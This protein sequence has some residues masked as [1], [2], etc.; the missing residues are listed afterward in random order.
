MLTLGPRIEENTV[1]SPEYLEQPCSTQWNR[2]ERELPTSHKVV[3]ASV[4]SSLQS[5]CPSPSLLFF[6]FRSLSLEPETQQGI[7]LVSHYLP[8]PLPVPTLAM[9]FNLSLSSDSLCD[10]KQIPLTSIA[11]SLNGIKMAL[12]IQRTTGEIYGNAFSNF[13]KGGFLDRMEFIV[14]RLFPK[15][16]SSLL[17]YMGF[18][19]QQCQSCLILALLSLACMFLNT[20]FLFALLFQIFTGTNPRYGFT[21]SKLNYMNSEQCF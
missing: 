8:S 12:R 1:F 11:H 3:L 21:D 18:I 15:E 17:Q 6:R 4:S 10:H 19:T 7:D 9:D 2:S 13:L 14:K 5:I 20:T 16:E